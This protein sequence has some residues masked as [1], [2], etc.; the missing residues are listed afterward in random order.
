ME[1]NEAVIVMQ[2]ILTSFTGK[3]IDSFALSKSVDGD[4]TI[5]YKLCIKGTFD[6]LSWEKMQ[7]IMQAYNLSIKE[8]NGFIIYVPKP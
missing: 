7:Q 4:R 3:W 5:G 2:E 6:E 8:E 1:R